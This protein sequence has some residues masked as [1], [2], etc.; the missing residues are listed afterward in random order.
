MGA[1]IQGDMI[2]QPAFP[3]DVLFL[4]LCVV[5]FIEFVEIEKSPILV[6]RSFRHNL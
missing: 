6:V 4:C 2:A 3:F 1:S 5:H